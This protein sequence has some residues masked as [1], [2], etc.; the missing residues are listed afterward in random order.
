MS[1]STGPLASPDDAYPI[2]RACTEHDRP[3]AP[4]HTREVFAA[5]LATP[6]A[7]HTTEYFLARLDGEPA[8]YLELMYPQA[9]NLGNV[10]VDL[11]V[12]PSAR[13]RGVGRALYRVAAERTRAAGRL[14]MLFESIQ[15][16]ASVAFAA[17]VGAD[18]A[19][20][21]LR[22]RLDLGAVHLRYD[23]MLTAA[24]E[25]AAGYHLIQWSGVPPEE[26]IEDVAALDSSF[27]AEAPTGDL[28]WEPE[29][30]D[31]DRVRAT[32]QSRT[33]RGRITFHTGAL[34]GDRLVAWTTLNCAIAGGEHAWQNATLVA[35]DHRGHRLG[36]L[37]KLANLAH[38][39]TY[40]PGLR[41]IDTFNAASNEHMLRINR[42]MG[43]RVVESVV[44]WQRDL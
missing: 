15:S 28:D 16:P 20:E 17:S 23:E 12:T 33:A 30:V 25:R 29:K 21:E 13:R 7:E 36:L 5:R 38:A 26:V 3:D 31:A 40:Q 27:L 19:L 18:A 42:Q 32:E 24:W 2:D 35:P 1:V 44:H 4:V 22:S 37:V 34:H 10:H 8:G 41:V 14:R 43:F 6:P 9:D 39:R 11:L